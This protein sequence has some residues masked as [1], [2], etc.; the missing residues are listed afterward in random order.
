MLTHVPGAHLSATA[1]HHIP[2]DCVSTKSHG[3]NWIKK[4][5][6]MP[7]VSLQA[8][9]LQHSLSCLCAL[10][11]SSNQIRELAHMQASCSIVSHST[12][13][14]PATSVCSAKSV[15]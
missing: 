8:A 11:N 6:G 13:A 15:N 12:A 10:Q 3:V 4:P 14:Q 5:A 2:P 1:L 9:A 7:A